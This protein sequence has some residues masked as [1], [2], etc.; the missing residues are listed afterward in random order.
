MLT[1][2]QSQ[3]ERRTLS[4]L[5][6]VL[7]GA[8]SPFAPLGSAAVT[9][10]T[11][12]SADNRDA[13][14]TGIHPPR[15]HRDPLRLAAT[16]SL[17]PHVYQACSPC[18]APTC[19]SHSTGKQRV[20]SCPPGTSSLFQVPFLPLSTSI[21]AVCFKYGNIFVRE[22]AWIILN[23]LQDEISRVLGRMCSHNKKELFSWRDPDTFLNSR[24][25]LL[26]CQHVPGM[27]VCFH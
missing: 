26:K 24:K 7:W 10:S 12:H 20:G 11:A 2:H 27:G 14:L 18:Q 17:G 13:C 23:L 8:R 19:C 5:D 3:N 1:W 15:S 16:R 9:S 4:Y 6:S 21:T 25:R 22:K